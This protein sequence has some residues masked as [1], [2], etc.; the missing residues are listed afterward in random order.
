MARYTTT[1]RTAMTPDAA[2]AFMAD[3]RNFEQ[4]DPGVQK[5]VQVTGDGAGPN[6]VFDVTVDVPGSGL[7]LR[8]ETTEYDAPKLAVVEA[9]STVFTSLDRIEVRPDGDG[10]LVTYDAELT[11]NGPLGIFDLALRPVFD[12]IGGRADE[13]LQQALDGEKV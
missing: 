9:R 5:S 1:V 11:L 6:A 8:Y 7:T 12:R 4:W 2:F 3:L 13:G 10:S